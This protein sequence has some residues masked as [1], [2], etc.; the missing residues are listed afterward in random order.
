MGQYTQAIQQLYVS[1]FSRPADKGGVQ[2]WESVAAATNGDFSALRNAFSGS[3]EYKTEYATKTNFQIV[4]QVYMNLFGRHA[5]L[6]GLQYWGDL[7][8][9]HAITVDH[10]V[11]Q[12]A[13]GARGSDSVAFNLKVATAT[14]FT[15]ALDT[16]AEIEGYR[17]TDAA[18]LGKLL[19]TCVVDDASYKQVI[20]PHGKLDMILEMIGSPWQSTTGPVIPAV[21]AIAIGE[22]NPNAA[23]ALDNNQAVHADPVQLIGSQVM[24]HHLAPL[25][26]SMF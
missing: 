4:D 10:V 25:Q 3:N 1:Y 18:A 12:V 13:G 20:A 24:A 15:D 9:R 23:P 22:P 14:L 26:F 16:V 17:G 8:N 2:Y 5:E 6:G 7:L 19:L 11:E 21:P